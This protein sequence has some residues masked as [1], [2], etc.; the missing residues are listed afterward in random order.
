[1]TTK[2]SAPYRAEI[3]GSQ[4]RPAL[5]LAKRA[6]YDAGKCTRDELKTVEDQAI[7][8]EVDKLLDVGIKAVTDGEFRRHMFFDGFFDNLDGMV[9][10][11]NPGRE[12][13]KMYVPDIKGFFESHA[14]KPASTMVCRSKL[15]RTK[16]MYRPEFEYTASL[17]KPDEVKNVKIT[18][19]APEW[20]HLRHG[21][22]AFSKDVYPTEVEYFADLA[23]AYREEL[24]DLYDAGCRNVQFD[25]PLLAYFC[26]TAMLDGMK[27]DGVD[28]PKVLD[29]Y[30][31][32][33][34]DCVRDVPSDMVIGLH[35]CRGNFKDG[36]HFSEGGYEHISK[37][38][39]NELNANVYYL[40]YDTDRAGG[41]EPLADL[42]ATKTVVLG[43]ISSKFPQLENKE[44]LV[45]R[46]H[47]AADF[48]A[49]GA[50]QTR[51][52]ALER[53]CLSPQCG[54]AS[55][56]EGNPV[57]HDD[58]WKKLGLVVETAKAVWSDA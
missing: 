35:L 56:A 3:I 2:T 28:A 33:Y 10:I 1:M 20:Y 6:D 38:L 5:L 26:S 31:Q 12:L 24:A 21:E 27:E 42:P 51:E 17:V 40:E 8:D 44:D 30:I 11:K 54:I 53:L 47:R 18:L 50:G 55:H 15:R 32:L 57:S 19:A 4:K 48:V 46:I 13:F 34:N 39:F 58:V 22:H 16:P 43:L 25:D 37:K 41:F 49:Q 45:E 14:S 7:K 9:E 29:Q 36:M 23:K 52:E